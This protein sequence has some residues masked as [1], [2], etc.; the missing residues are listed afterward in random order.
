[1]FYFFFLAKLLNF[2]PVRDII[3]RNRSRNY[4]FQS[5]VN[6]VGDLCVMLP[7][8]YA[9]V[10]RFGKS[11]PIWIHRAFCVGSFS[12]KMF[13]YILALFHL[14]LLRKYLWPTLKS[15]C[16]MDQ[17]YRHL[18]NALTKYLKGADVNYMMHTN[19]YA[20]HQKIL[21]L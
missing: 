16:L 17:L 19:T 11:R 14:T 10:N 13:H 5:G 21:K 9:S 3:V 18:I 8:R 4:V 20:L 7:W 6:R 2:P 1:M 12:W 15:T